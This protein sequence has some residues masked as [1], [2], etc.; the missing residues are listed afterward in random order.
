[1]G[2]ELNI[3]PTFIIRQFIKYSMIAKL[4][5]NRNRTSR[6]VSEMLRDPE[7]SHRSNG[8]VCV[9]G[10]ECDEGTLGYS[11]QRRKVYQWKT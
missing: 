8:A 1:M 6:I 10:V 11:Y 7:C 5:K 3:D 2:L 9:Y 4:N